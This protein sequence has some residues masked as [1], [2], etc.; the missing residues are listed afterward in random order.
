M[1]SIN[2]ERAR[3]FIPDSTYKKQLEA[4]RNSLQQIST[5]TGRGSEWL[6]WNAIPEEPDYAEIDKIVSHAERI[7]A[8]ADIFIVRSEERRV[9]KGGRGRGAAGGGEWGD[10]SG[11]R[12]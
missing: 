4:A 7:R 9:G 3:T 1:I 5:K 10:G 2:T 8:H 11:E 12:G 6:G